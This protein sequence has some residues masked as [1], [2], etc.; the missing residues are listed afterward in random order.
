MVSDVTRVSRG[1]IAVTRF[2]STQLIPLLDVAGALVCETGASLCSLAT[3]ARECTIPMVIC[4]RAGVILCDGDVITVDGR[5][6]IIRR[7]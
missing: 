1:D 4:E 2:A 5:S 7:Q 6:G 3:L